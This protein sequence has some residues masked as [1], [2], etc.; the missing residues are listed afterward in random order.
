MLICAFVFK[1]ED[2]IEDRF[3]KLGTARLK[4]AEIYVCVYKTEQE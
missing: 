3:H 4:L 2:Q 1:F